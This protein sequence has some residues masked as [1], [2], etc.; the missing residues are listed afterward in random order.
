MARRNKSGTAWTRDDILLA[1]VETY[2]LLP[3]PS[4]ASTSAF[5]T[6][7][8]EYWPTASA[9]TRAH[10]EGQLRASK[11]LDLR[12]LEALD[13]LTDA[14]R[15]AREIEARARLEAARMAAPAA[16]KVAPAIGVT[17]AGASTKDATGTT[18]ARSGAASSVVADEPK[19]PFEPFDE[20]AEG[21]VVEP[22]R[23]A[24]LAAGDDAALA[25]GNVAAGAKVTGGTAAA[26]AAI[27]PTVRTISRASAPF[28]RANGTSG[29]T[30]E[31]RDGRSAGA[32][33]KRRRF[34]VR[35]SLT[36]VTAPASTGTSEPATSSGSVRDRLR[37]A[38]GRSANE[39]GST[40]ATPAPVATVLPL[41]EGDRQDAAARTMEASAQAPSTSRAPAPVASHARELLRHL[42]A[43]GEPGPAIQIPETVRRLRETDMPWV[44]MA[45]LLR[46][47]SEAGNWIIADTRGT[48]VALRALGVATGDARE[49]VARWH[50]GAPE[51]FAETYEALPLDDCLEIVATWRRAAGEGRDE[52][53]TATDQR[54]SA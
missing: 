29:Q 27:T 38:V 37:A 12:A 10:V 34:V 19:A 5:L 43:T 25:A 17:A 48:A 45:V 15:A 6:L 2:I 51:G 54:L 16:T 33:P 13:E 21:A 9:G 36:R 7:L 20:A 49:L 35:Q 3:R 30:S 31:R 40:K 41:G 44:E 24:A 28:A 14:D 4:G 46:L 1:T 8:K 42:S 11:R 26:P 53:G 18:V 23:D 22:V 50:H 32:E 52:D 47:P 39:R